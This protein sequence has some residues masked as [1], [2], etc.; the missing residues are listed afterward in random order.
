MALLIFSK[1]SNAPP[2]IAGLLDTELRRNVAMKVNEA[3]LKNQ[4]SRSQDKLKSLVQFRAWTERQARAQNRD[5]PD[6]LDI[7]TSNGDKTLED[8]VMSQDGDA[9]PEHVA[10]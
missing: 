5:I 10:A 1:D 9:E 7:W 2:M 3:I 6:R 8:T 4:G